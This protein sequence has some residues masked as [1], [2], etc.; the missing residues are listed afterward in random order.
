MRHGYPHKPR[1]TDAEKAAV[2][3]DTALRISAA[4]YNDL[5][6]LVN[7]AFH[8]QNPIQPIKEEPM[9][10]THVEAVAHVANV[11]T[12]RGT[13]I[14]GSKSETFI[15]Y[16]Q[17]ALPNIIK[18]IRVH[19]TVRERLADQLEFNNVVCALIDFEAQNLGSMKLWTRKR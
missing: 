12:Y 11:K 8:D 14:S 2:D 1:R 10:T 6:G 5:A 15:A 3:A 9:L 7:R 19:V 18:Q 17:F 4:E 13:L 16:V